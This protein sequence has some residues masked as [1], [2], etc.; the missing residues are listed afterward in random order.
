MYVD[1]AFMAD[2]NL[3]KRL[4]NAPTPRT[5]V[6][7]VFVVEDGELPTHRHKHISHR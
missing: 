4:Y 3:Y 7:A 5:E 2:W 1:M 6:A